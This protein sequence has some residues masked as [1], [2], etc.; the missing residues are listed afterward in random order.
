MFTIETICAWC[1]MCFEDS[2]TLKL[3]FE[4]L[5]ENNLHY[6][7]LW[8]KMQ[9]VKI[10]DKKYINKKKIFYCIYNKYK[11]DIYIFFFLLQYITKR[12]FLY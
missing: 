12:S 4:T 6:I 1:F 3:L 5:I 9:N 2:S 11:S 10:A 7:M 8:E